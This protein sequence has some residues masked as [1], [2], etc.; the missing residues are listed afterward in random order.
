[1]LPSHYSV[2]DVQF[3]MILLSYSRREQVHN[4]VKDIL[5]YKLVT[6]IQQSEIPLVMVGS[7]ELVV[8]CAVNLN[9]N[10]IKFLLVIPVLNTC[11]LHIM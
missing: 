10:S 7:F 5:C 11:V 9:R 1:M 2:T 8:V 6:R 3:A 4:V